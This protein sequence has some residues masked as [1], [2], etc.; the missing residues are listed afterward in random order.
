MKTHAI[1]VTTLAACLLVTSALAQS[2]NPIEEIIVTARGRTESLLRVPD[3]V[4]IF[5]R[6]ALDKRQ[7][8]N[9]ED[10]AASVPG[11][12]IINDQDP[13]T[14]VITI[15]GVSTDRLQQA[16][17][18]YVVDGVAMADKELFTQPYFDLERV[19]IL[20]GPQGALYGKNAIGG[21]FSLT[22]RAPSDVVDGFI[23]AD[24]GNGS[25]KALRGAVGGPLLGRKL[26]V[27]VA[28]QI[29]DWDGWIRNSFLKRYVDYQTTRN[30]RIRAAGEP[31][32]DW[33][34]EWRW[35]VNTED[36]GAAWVSSGN[37]TGMFKGRLDGPALT[38]PFGDFEGTAQRNWYGVSFKNDVTVNDG[39]LSAI[40]GYDHY[41]KRWFEELDFRNDKPITFLGAPFFPNGIQPISQPVD[42]RFWTGEVRYTSADDAPV[43]WIAGVFAQDT[44]RKR[45]DDFG[46]LLF[47]AEASAYRTPT[48]QLAA[49]AQATTRWAERFETTLA[50]RYDSVETSEEISG[51]I[52]ARRIDESAKTFKQL[53]PKL[54]LTYDIVDSAMIYGSISRGFKPGGFNPRPGPTDTFAR[55]Y[56]AETTTAYEIG[57][58]GSSADGRLSASTAAFYTYYANYQY[59]AFINGNNTTYTAPKVK[60]TGFELSLNAKPATWMMIDGAFAYTDA[61]IGTFRAPDPITGIGLRTYTGNQTP[62]SP[63]WNLSGGLELSQPIKTDLAASLRGDV[64]VRGKTF[65]EIDNALYSP[66]ETALNLRLAL[67]SS[68]WSA[69]V[70]A[71]NLTDNRWAVSAFGQGQIALLAFLGPNGPFDSFN[72]NRGR[73]YGATVKANF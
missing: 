21:V 17:V 39:T 63:R 49:F 19:E 14:N 54:S 59:F 20:K 28:G 60:V 58:K 3:S 57:A 68:S 6:A 43:R 52:S 26:M 37:V 40:A 45:V 62:N 5:D 41:R 47:G 38:N 8:V 31:S 67:T 2:P 35:N 13:G 4:A 51:V 56:K 61:K 55:I 48:T 22:T 70:W 53:Q 18:A 27:R 73:Q 12:F 15:R 29:Q 72:I 64:Q 36:S 24:I 69:A 1:S 32:D 71:K 46:P 50:L 33:R 65:F 11:V 16:S 34:W 9:F 23:E 10:V 66:T 30:L 44:L 7:V 42:L 25:N